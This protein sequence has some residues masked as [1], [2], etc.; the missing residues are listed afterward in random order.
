LVHKFWHLL[1]SRLLLLKVSLAAFRRKML[2][3][4]LFG[5]PCNYFFELILI[6]FY[7]LQ[8]LR[9][10]LV[11]LELLAILL[12]WS[13]LLVD[14]LI[15]PFLIVANHLQHLRYFCLVVG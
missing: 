10:L 12:V 11:L 8:H 1:V 9:Q 15:K 2:E 6:F 7:C 5:L 3:P 14:H 13:C 4:L